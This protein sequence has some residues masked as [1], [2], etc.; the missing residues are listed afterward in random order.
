[1]KKTGDIIFY[2]VLS[3]ILVAGCWWSFLLYSKNEEAR[4][5]SIELAQQ[6]QP[7]SIGLKSK[8]NKKF[9]R[10]QWM[11]LGEGFVL[12]S[13]LIFGLIRV[14]Q[15][16]RKEL[17][18]ALQ[19]RNFLLSITHELK[20]PITSVQLAFETLLKRDL[21]KNQRDKLIHKAL[22]DNQRLHG[23]VQ[24]LLYAAKAE[25]KL[26]LESVRVDLSKLMFEVIQSFTLAEG[27]KLV[28]DDSRETFFTKA[29]P[30]ALFMVF[31]NLIDNAFKY[32]GKESFVQIRIKKLNQ[33]IH[34]EV[35]DNG[36]GISEIEKSKIFDKFYRVGNEDVRKFK[37]AGLGLYIVK[38][39]ME[40][41]KAEIIVKSELE[42]G[43]VFLL[44]F[45]I[46]G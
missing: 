39:I 35:E 26:V 34:I 16:R 27:Q 3:Y 29:D 6:Q 28:F 46:D 4:K 14:N 37:G 20:S 43:S 23:L 36:P 41:H 19:Q 7:D 17:R 24:D 33:E 31:R 42:K 10:Q 30:K 13:L 11:I 1:M 45:L 40:A 8:L 18:L 38:K 5:L 22:Q 21:E 25:E 44:K 12:M 2:L 9:D 32:A 15:M